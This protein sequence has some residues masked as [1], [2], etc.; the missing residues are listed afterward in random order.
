MNREDFLKRIELE[1]KYLNKY[2]S[3]EKFGQFHYLIGHFITTFRYID[4]WENELLPYFNTILNGTGI[5]NDWN[6]F[7]W[8]GTVCFRYSYVMI[9]D[10]SIHK[11]GRKLPGLYD[12]S[13]NQILNEEYDW[14]YD[15]EY[16]RTHY[17]EF[18]IISIDE[19]IQKCKYWVQIIKL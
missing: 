8:K 16:I 9:L 15:T 18:V 7:E 13:G 17:T 6:S 5:I 1:K 4:Q 12:N 14:L 3:K 10:E 11:L 19:L 2:C